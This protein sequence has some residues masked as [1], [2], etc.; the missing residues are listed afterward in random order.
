MASSNRN[1]L[2]FSVGARHV[3]DPARSRGAVP[4]RS[5]ALCCLLALLV[6]SIGSGSAIAQESPPTRPRGEVKYSVLAVEYIGESDKPVTPVVISD[7]K[8]GA[9]WFRNT[10]LKK[11]ELGLTYIHVVNALLLEKLL[12]NVEAHKG[13]IQPNG[14]KNKTRSK[15]VSVTAITPGSESTFLYDT[16]EATSLLE[17]LQKSCDR[18]DALRTDLAHFQDRIRH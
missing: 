6:F 13:T 3:E 8:A 5:S 12:A 17:G 4:E 1:A 16:R 11:N 2:C 9:A 18:N 7:S 15:T 14:E 10:V